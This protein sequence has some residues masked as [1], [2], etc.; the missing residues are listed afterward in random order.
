MSE[1][2]DWLRQ[3]REM[4]GLTLEDAERDTRISRRYLYALESGE[5]D[6][7][8][9][10]VYARGFLRSYAQYLGLDPQEAMAR[11][12]RDDAGPYTPPGAT[13]VRLPDPRAQ[14]QQSGQRP[15][16]FGRPRVQAEAPASPSPAAG[17]ARPTWRRPG[18]PEQGTR[19]PARRQEAE[20]GLEAVHEP[21]IGVDIG[22]PVPARRL[23]QDP[24]AQTRSMLVLGVALAAVLGIL[25]LAFLLSRMGGGG[26]D[27]SV[28]PTS[29]G[30][31]ANPG[32]T[33]L[34]TPTTQ[35]ATTGNGIVPDVVGDL[36]AD[37]VAAITAAGLVPNVRPVKDDA[38][39]GT[40]IEQSP[41]A[42]AQLDPGDPMTI[43]VSE[44]P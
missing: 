30:G 19:P 37:A 26:G 10:P 31:G 2:G 6:L 16:A 24:A 33:G 9:A 38:T 41:D 35:A 39:P 13:G 15:P 3:A 42:G 29:E 21:M 18:P 27:G 14:Q 25:A 44:G 8:P 11:Y 1:L 20:P 17:G 40:V 28:V 23:Q 4:R 43:V 12:P 7:I 36:Q 34:T 22:V 32:G 5:L